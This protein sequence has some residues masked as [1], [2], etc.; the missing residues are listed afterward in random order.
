MCVLLHVDG[1]PDSLALARALVREARLGV[2]PGMAFG[3]VGESFLR[4]CVAQPAAALQDVTE[5]L[6]RL[7][8]P[9]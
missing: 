3:N 5:R 7:L 4:W 8:A 1:E 6:A 2:A 9:R